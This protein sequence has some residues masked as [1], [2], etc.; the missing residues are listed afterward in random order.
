MSKGIAFFLARG[1]SPCLVC[2][3]VFMSLE[4]RQTDDDDSH[5]GLR[6]GL[7][8]GRR[9]GHGM[10]PRDRGASNQHFPA[11][12]AL[13]AE[14]SIPMSMPIPAFI[15]IAH[16]HSNLQQVDFEKIPISLFKTSDW[17]QQPLNRDS[18]NW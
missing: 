10:F 2:C 5:V 15:N 7:K 4:Q 11:V 9:L 6:V 18:F 14:M 16:D 12:A 3:A 13:I 1:I 8:H 17:S